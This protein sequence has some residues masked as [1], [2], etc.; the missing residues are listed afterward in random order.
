MKAR[1][2]QRLRVGLCVAIWPF[3]CERVD[4]KCV[5]R[6]RADRESVD[7]EYANRELRG[8]ESPPL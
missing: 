6:E 3:R 4:R 5:N 7:R 1:L 2:F 8:I